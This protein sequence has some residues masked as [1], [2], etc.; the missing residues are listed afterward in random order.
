MQLQRTF[1]PLF[2]PS[3]LA[4]ALPCLLAAAPAL[5]HADDA[6]ETLVV[7]G[8]RQAAA[9]S[10][11]S[12]SVAAIDSDTLR[13]QMAGNLQD[14][15]TFEPGVEMSG[16]GKFGLGAFNIRGMTDDRVKVL[17]DGIEQP[18][19]FNAGK[20]GN[21]PHIDV[22]NEYGT[23]IEIDTLTAIEIN[24]NA[25]SSLFGSDA[26]GGAVMLRTKRPD[27]LLQGQRSALG[28]ILGYNG[29]N[30]EFKSTVES[31]HDFGAWQG[32]AIYTYRDGHETETHDDG[33]DVIGVTR[34]QA[35]P[36]AFRSHNLL[37]KSVSQLNSD[38]ELSLTAE[39][40]QRDY[41]TDLLSMEGYEIP[42]RRPGALPTIYTDNRMEQQQQRLRLTAEHR[43]QADLDW[44]DQS[45]L[46]LSWQQA[47]SDN[48]NYR[49]KNIDCLEGC[50]LVRNREDSNLQLHSQFD[51]EMLWSSLAQ[52][53]SYGVSVIRSEFDSFYEDIELATGEHQSSTTTMPKAHAWRTGLFAK[54]QLELD[55][56]P[57]QWDMG[58]R[59]DHYE[60]RPD[61]DLPEHNSDALTFNLGALYRMTA[62]WS[63]YATVNTGY[64][65][66]SLY[67]LYYRLDLPHV[68]VAPNPDL[69]AEHSINYELG[70][71]WIGDNATLEWATYLNDYRDFIEVAIIEHGYPEIR[72]AVN[73]GEVRIYGSELKAN[74]EPTALPGV[75]LQGGLAWS[76]GENRLTG[77]SLDTVAPVNASLM[78][79]YDAPGEAWG[80]A[81]QNKY[82]AEKSGSDWGTE[83]NL[84]APSYFVMNLTSYW[85]ARP[86]L[87]LSFGIHN[88]TDEQYWL[89]GNLAGRIEDPQQNIDRFS[90]SGRYVSAQL[91]Y[92]L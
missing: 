39:L 71:R 23:G 72:Q 48:D 84:T 69:E 31:A 13:R 30:R 88:L 2:T 41:D 1:A 54:Q 58:L 89:Y 68:T 45:L 81:L 11:V 49:T 27:D 59:Y 77:E 19:F 85:Q 26:I 90:Q 5:V 83:G 12:G 3:V 32:L 66:P 64:R 63:G 44:F 7:V 20:N 35:D 8:S 78:L 87:R 50:V 86:D 24:K 34:G 29:A 61:S 53:L 40:Y 57:L 67:D 51:K 91:Q 33:A 65:A 52:R 9:I 47:Q 10:D 16:I 15:I 55:N 73:V 82:S 4:R 56:L 43:W 42:S 18:I 70:L 74:W 36:A 14:A 21:S 28:V 79:A 92:Q 46:Q 80:V 62:Q 25:A 37:L 6:T 75:S 22:I 60:A 17:I 38:H 76:E